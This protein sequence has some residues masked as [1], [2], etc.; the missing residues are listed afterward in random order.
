MI[1]HLTNCKLQGLFPFSKTSF[2]FNRLKCK[3]Y[4][5]I[6]RKF[7]GTNGQPSEVFHFFRSDPSSRKL[8]LK[9][10]RNFYFYLFLLSSCLA[11][12]LL[13]HVY[14]FLSTDEIALKFETS[15][16]LFEISN[17]KF[18]RLNGKLPKARIGSR[19]THLYEPSMFTH[20]ASWLHL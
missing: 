11:P 13:H 20:F 1:S 17:Q 8:Q 7:S 15:G 4:A 18:W 14:V 19:Y 10:A 3:W 16:K 2:P 6:K 9:F 5:P 12:L